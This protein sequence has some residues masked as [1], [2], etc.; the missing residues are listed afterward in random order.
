MMKRSHK[1]NCSLAF[2]ADILSERWTLLVVRELLLKPRRYGELLNNLE[3]MGTNLLASRLKEMVALELLE[4][5]AN[6]Y[7][8][9]KLGQGLEPSVLSLIRWGLNLSS[10]RTSPSYLHRNEWDILAMKALFNKLSSVAGTIRLQLD[11]PEETNDK[12]LSAWIE[13]SGDQ[14][15]F[16]FDPTSRAIDIHWSKPLSLLSTELPAQYLENPSEEQ[17]LAQFLTAFN[18]D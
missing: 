3:G 16:G 15:T 9:T 2:A 5:K 12:P 1:Q 18:H 11:I 10:S 17:A 7:Q 14:F 4:K 6:R 13:I 8:L